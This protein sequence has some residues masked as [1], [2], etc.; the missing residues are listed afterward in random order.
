MATSRPYCPT[1]TGKVPPFRT[2]PLAPWLPWSS[3][4]SLFRFGQQARCFCWL[5]AGWRSRP[6]A[7]AHDQD[8]ASTAGT[9]FA[10][11]PIAARSAAHQRWREPSGTFDPF[12]G[13]ENARRAIR[14]H[15]REVYEPSLVALLFRVG[16]IGIREMIRRLFQFASTVSLLACVAALLLSLFYWRSHQYARTGRLEWWFERRF[17]IVGRYDF[18]PVKLGAPLPTSRPWRLTVIPGLRT[19]VDQVGGSGIFILH[20]YLRVDYWGLIGSTA[21]LPAIFLI[22]RVRNRRR[23]RPGCCWHCGYDLRASAKRCP[24][25]GMAF[26]PEQTAGSAHAG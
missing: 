1:R 9:I 13:S 3:P 11:R 21:V 5:Q 8:V 23:L 6:C 17:L 4:P 10:R 2:F 14:R 24:E 7:T 26:P 16:S 12:G 25:C 19:G 15:I 18:F 20:P 22:W